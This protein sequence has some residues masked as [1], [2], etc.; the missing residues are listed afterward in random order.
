MYWQQSARDQLYIIIKYVQF[1]FSILN[2][3][4][5]PSEVPGTERSRLR[6][7]FVQGE[8]VQ[9]DDGQQDRC[10]PPGHVEST[11]QQGGQSVADL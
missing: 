4:I 7:Q 11:R 6:E 5:T 9:A 10:E 3:Q 1:I 8:T 2:I